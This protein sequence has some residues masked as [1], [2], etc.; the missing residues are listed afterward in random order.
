MNKFLRFFLVAALV[1][2]FLVSCSRP[3]IPLQ[4]VRRPMAYAVPKPGEKMNCMVIT[5]GAECIP[6][7]RVLPRELCAALD[8]CKQEGDHSNGAL[9]YSTPFVQPVPELYL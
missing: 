6:V 7:R 9:I 8:V 1:P 4:T 2:S 5:T 3:G